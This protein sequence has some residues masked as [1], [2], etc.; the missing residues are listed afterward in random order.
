[1]QAATANSSDRVRRRV[2][3][4]MVAGGGDGEIIMPPA[5]DAVHVPGCG[6]ATALTPLLA[7]AR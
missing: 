7:A 4:D 6:V 1:V 5:T 2:R 3:E